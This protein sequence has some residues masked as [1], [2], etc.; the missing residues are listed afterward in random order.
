VCFVLLANVG[1]GIGRFGL[2][3]DQ[4]HNAVAAAS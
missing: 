4:L 1:G 2:D 3:A